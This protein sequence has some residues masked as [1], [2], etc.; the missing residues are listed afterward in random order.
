MSVMVAENTDSKHTHMMHNRMQTHYAR[1]KTTHGV[2]TQTGGAWET[3]G[4]ETFAKGTSVVDPVSP[5]ACV[6]VCL[7]VCESG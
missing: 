7:C 6:S 3:G 2:Q 4:A 5:R 1:P